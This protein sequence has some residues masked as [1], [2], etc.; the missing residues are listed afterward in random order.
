MSFAGR[1]VLVTGGSRGIGRAIVR[2]LASAGF[3]VHFTWHENEV[4]AHQVAADGGGPG[5]VAAHRLDVRDARACEQ[6]VEAG[7]APM[8]LG[9]R[10]CVNENA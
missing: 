3:A 7:L 1:R 4:A 8:K 5:R 6:V 2:E 10:P 9:P